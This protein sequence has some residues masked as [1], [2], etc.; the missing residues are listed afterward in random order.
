MA[1]TRRSSISVTITN[2]ADLLRAEVDKA[3]KRKPVAMGHTVR[4]KL[5]TEVLV[6]QRNGR[7]YRVPKTN[8]MYQASRPGEPPASRLG[9][10]RRSYQVGRVEGTNP[11]YSVKVGSAL[12]YALY[13]ETGMNRKHLEP[14]VDLAMPD[15]IAIAQG[16]WGI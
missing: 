8:R 1:K 15:L 4:D 6:G 5:L 3:L 16:D 11:N 10:L 12:D 7:W 9:D 2:R 14:A 13:L